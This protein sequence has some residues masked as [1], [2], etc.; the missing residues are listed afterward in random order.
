MKSIFNIL[1]ILS[2][3]FRMQAQ[4]NDWPVFRGKGTLNGY[5]E[6]VIPS[7]PIYLWSVTTGSRTKS[8]P[9][10]SEGMIYFGTDKGI[11]YAV[12]S[13][14]KIKWKYE[15]G[16]PMEAPPLIYSGKVI[17]GSSDGIISAI[18]KIN[19]KPLWS[20]KTDNKIVG[21][22]NVWESGTKSGIVSG[23]YDYYLHCVD[24]IYWKTSVEN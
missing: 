20:Y 4:I 21:S 8:S 18:D 9:V 24:P 16:S 2:I 13:E 19:G 5:T 7:S 12:S 17:A 6:S 3:T 11:I 23:S 15:T 14:G 10:L 22:A 1:L